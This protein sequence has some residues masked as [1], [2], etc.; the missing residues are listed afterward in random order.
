MKE[1]LSRLASTIR[2]C[3]LMAP[4]QEVLVAVSGGPDSVFLAW[5]LRELGYSIGLAHVNYHLRGQDSEN[6]ESLIR[7]YARQWNAPVFVCNAEP[8]EYA[9]LH[10]TSLQVACR[11]IR[12]EWFEQILETQDFDC[13]ATA[14][15]INDQ[16][17]SVLMSL[18]RGNSES[19]IR[20]IPV[21]RG[22]YIR[23]LVEISKSE[24]LMALQENGLAYSLDYTNEKNDYLRNQFRN[25]VIPLLVEINP[26]VESHLQKRLLWYQQQQTF[27]RKIIDADRKKMISQSEKTFRLNWG[28][29]EK[30]YGAEHLPVLVA[31]TVSGWGLHGNEIWQSVS[32]IESQP[33]KWIETTEG[34]LTRIR[35]GLLF[36]PQIEN[37]PPEPP[38]V[39]EHFP[40]EKNL[41]FGGWKIVF[42]VQKTAV[43]PAFHGEHL[44]DIDMIRFPLRIRS[45]Q[46]GDRMKPLGMKGQ[47]KLSDIF[48][49]NKSDPRAKAKAF[50]LEDQEGIIFL[51][52]YRIADR[53]K[54]TAA[55]Q[56]IGKIVIYG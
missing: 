35:N 25:Q 46:E 42:S 6:E 11:N 44:M 10:K 34:T 24:I 33:G 32:L 19:V 47:K 45:W 50:V 7:E 17:E 4:D 51:S 16:A 40:E 38:L 53:V 52:E 9:R 14:H 28:I 15:H 43:L 2:N 55:S 54:I 22:P 36:Q 12:Y 23:P 5:A 30:K 21:Q 37:L 31:E 39:I 56:Q 18:I 48:T 13:C 29:F 8:H 1:L 41:S 27:I 49:D 20:G 26:T 3:D